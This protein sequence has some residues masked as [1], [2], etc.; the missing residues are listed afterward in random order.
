[1]NETYEVTPERA[2]EL[3]AEDAYQ[4]MRANLLPLVLARSDEPKI[5][6]AVKR[7]GGQ[8]LLELH[9]LAL[10]FEVLL[11]IG[12]RRT[13]IMAGSLHEDAAAA[14]LRDTLGI[15]LAAA[16]TFDPIER[17]KHGTQYVCRLRI[18]EGVESFRMYL[19][20]AGRVIWQSPERAVTFDPEGWLAH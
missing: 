16:L 1:M 9:P 2:R 6:E 20:Q 12:S 5:R 13:T 19:V 8:L 18:L 11:I 17:V 3:A 7:R 14:D 4:L 10:V 15:A